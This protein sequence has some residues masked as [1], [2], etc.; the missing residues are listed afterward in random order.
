MRST[1]Y[2]TEQE[3]WALSKDPAQR[4]RLSTV[5]ATAVHGLGTLA[6]LLSPVLPKATARLWDGDRRRRSS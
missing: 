1:C 2:I 4:D 5:L 3:P 6:V